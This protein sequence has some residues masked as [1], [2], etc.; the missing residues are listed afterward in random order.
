MSIIKKL[1]KL[2]IKETGFGSIILLKGCIKMLDESIIKQIKEYAED[3][4]VP[5]MTDEGII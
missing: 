5:I 4:N 3:N 1:K 2:K